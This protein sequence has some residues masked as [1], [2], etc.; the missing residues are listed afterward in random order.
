MG[1]P[2]I[3]QKEKKK[4]RISSMMYLGEP[5]CEL[6]L[7]ECN[8]TNKVGYVY[9][10]PGWPFISDMWICNEC[11]NKIENEENTDVVP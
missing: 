8:A 3:D 10:Q 11:L 1:G 2:F 5:A 9:V 7:K 6:C 4:S